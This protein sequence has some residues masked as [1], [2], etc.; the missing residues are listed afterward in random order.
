MHVPERPPY[1]K[2]ALAY[3]AF[4]ALSAFGVYTLGALIYVVAT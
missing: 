3:T 4:T 2:L 1:W